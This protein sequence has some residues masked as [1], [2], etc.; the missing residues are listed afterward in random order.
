LILDNHSSHLSDDTTKEFEENNITYIP[1]AANTTPICQPVDGEIDC[2]IKS[3]IK[4]YF[5][6]WLINSLGKLCKFYEGIL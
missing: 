6:E 1:L 5:E 2:I 4:Y 3:I